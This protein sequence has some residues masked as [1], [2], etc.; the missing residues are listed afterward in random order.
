MSR[1]DDRLTDTELDRLEEFLNSGIFREQAMPIDM[2]QGMLCAVASSPDAIAPS[3]WIEEALG[4]DQEFESA[5]QAEAFMGLLM[6]FYNQTVEELADGKGLTFYVFPGDDGEDDLAT[7]CDGYLAG[8]ELS[9]V[10]W[11]THGEEAVVEE[12]LAPLVLLSGRMRQAAE[13]DGAELP[14]EEDERELMQ[15][16]RAALPD[17]VL[18][19]HRYWMERRGRGMQG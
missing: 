5:E 11:Y 12:M 19:L 10:N 18:D 14:S 17:T 6:R 2:L 4:Q 3:R 8:M 15:A 1:S 16:A 9:E 13:E 7:W